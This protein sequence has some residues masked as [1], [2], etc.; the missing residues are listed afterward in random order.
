MIL[1]P[2]AKINIG[3]QIIEKRPDGFHNIASCFYPVGWADVLEVIPAERFS[4]SISG[5]PIPGDTAT[6]L[7]VKAYELLQ[8]DF[9]IP[10]V[11]MHLLKI[12]PIGAGMGG[13]SSDAAF[14]LKL[15]NSRFLLGLSTQ[16][17]E[18][19]ARQL[20]SDCAFFIGNKPQY[21]YEKGDRFEDIALSLRGKSIVLVYPNL[22]I[23]T[24][25]AYAGVKP[26]PP[27]E[28]LSKILQQPISAW[29]YLIKN[30][31]EE[32]LFQKYPV[33]PKIKNQLYEMGAVYASMTGSGSTIFGIFENLPSIKNN[34][35]PYT[36]W[37][38]ELS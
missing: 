5:L 37:I 11:A 18:N 3:L 6:N 38:G 13:G 29:K 34:F 7:C 1:F 15:L 20:G 35:E 9:D 33:L 19:Y 4:F 28:N 14:A 8:K 2:N 24:A 17:L 25:E 12:V 26:T 23:S 22:H 32:G 27:Q 30:D 36:V 31:F 21:C 16:N 10:P